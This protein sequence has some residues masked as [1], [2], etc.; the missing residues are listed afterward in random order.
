MSAAM[1]LEGW[2]WEEMT[3][4]P[5]V[6][7]IVNWPAMQYVQ[8]P[9]SRQT[10]EQ[11]TKRR[12]D[13]LKLLKDSFDN[14]RAYM[15]AKQAGE[16]Q[17][18]RHIETNP[19][20]EAMIPVL[21]GD[22]PIIVNAY[23]VAQIQASVSFAEHQGVR[24]ILAG[25]YDAW[26]IAP[27]LAEK[28]IP[29][30]LTDVQNARRRWEP[31]DVVFTLPQKFM[32]SGVQYC[33]TGDR[34][35]ANIRNLSHHAANASAYGLPREEALKA[36]T[37]YPAQILGI[38]DR[39]GSLEPGKDA[40]LFISDGDALEIS[41]RVEQVYITGRKVDMNDKHTRLYRKY[42]EKYRQLGK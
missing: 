11:W 23:D 25:A 1:M 17:N 20:W 38:A 9:F 18:G 14:A 27:M 29:V 10:K 39:V 41:S 2:T 8:S 15:K 32:E 19:T 6:G 3:L 34:S 40:T 37:L 33:I 42:Q 31:Y 5:N 30:I 4:K 35:P 22:V 26:P 16:E 13:N 12:D 28:Q 24:L 21:K 7:L 36:I